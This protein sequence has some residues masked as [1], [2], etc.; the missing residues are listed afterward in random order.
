MT[1][2]QVVICLEEIGVSTE[3]PVW[4]TLEDKLTHIGL[5]CDNTLSVSPKTVQYYFDVFSGLLFVRHT[6]GTPKKIGYSD[7]IPD[8]YAVIS[9]NNIPYIVKIEGG[10]CEDQHAGRFHEVIS[11]DMITGLFQNKI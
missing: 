4:L 6:F 5:Q 8:G 1:K 10:G 7:P 2:N 9:H 11:F 3:N